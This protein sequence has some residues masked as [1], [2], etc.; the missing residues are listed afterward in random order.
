VTGAVARSAVRR[1]RGRRSAQRAETAAP[2][3]RTRP[4][5]GN[6]PGGVYDGL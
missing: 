4:G 5:R 3:G 6:S 1:R 2:I